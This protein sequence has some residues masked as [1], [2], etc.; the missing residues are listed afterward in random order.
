M[1]SIGTVKKEFD[2]HLRINYNKFGL[3]A[4]EIR[5]VLK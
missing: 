1:P 4:K 3:Q 5:Q 2:G